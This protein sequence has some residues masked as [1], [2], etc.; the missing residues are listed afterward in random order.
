MAIKVGGTTVIDDSRNLT[1]SGNINLTQAF[2]ETAN[3]TASAVTANVTLV[4]KD[5]GICYFTSN[6]T[7]NATVN[8]THSVFASQSQFGG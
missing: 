8:S 4:A 7:A 3:V 6:A 1:L 5:S 2:F